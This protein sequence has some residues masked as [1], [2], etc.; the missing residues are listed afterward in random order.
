MTTQGKKVEYRYF[1]LEELPFF[2]R[3]IET[4]T[5]ICEIDRTI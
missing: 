3:V 2:P 5:T 1:L 4:V